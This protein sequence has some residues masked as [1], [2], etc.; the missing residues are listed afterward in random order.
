MLPQEARET[1]REVRKNTMNGV[2]ELG[3]KALRKSIVSNLNAG[4]ASVDVNKGCPDS[5]T[6]IRKEV[7]KRSKYE[8]EARHRLRGTKILPGR[9][10]FSK[11]KEA[12]KLLSPSVVW[13]PR[14]A[15]K[16][17]GLGA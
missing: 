3:L 7:R 10:L 4:I 15:L 1:L 13:D 5:A 14:K 6:E 16:I 12:V 9:S 2:L 17:I 8:R 11:D